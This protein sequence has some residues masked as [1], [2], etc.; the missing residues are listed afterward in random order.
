MA[1]VTIQEIPITTDENSVTIDENPITTGETP[2]KTN[3]ADEKPE[4][5][6]ADVVALEPT[7]KRKPGRPVGS[8]NKEPQKPRKPRVKAVAP[9]EEPV[10]VEPPMPPLP[11][12]P[13]DRPALPGSRRIPTQARDSRE[14]MMLRLLSHQANARQQNKVAMW[15]SWFH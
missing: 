2:V 13:Y 11:D 7:P 5:L 4:A 9:R 14:A 1:E 6:P 8:K 3:E 12:H 15:K 10:P